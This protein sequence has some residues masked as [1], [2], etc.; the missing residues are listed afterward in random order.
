L[1]AA[2]GGI[3]S[4]D[5]PARHSHRRPL[6]MG[7]VTLGGFLGRRVDLNV[8][9]LLAGFDSPVCLGFEADALGDGWQGDYRRRGA[10]DTDLHKWLEAACCA[11]AGAHGELGTAIDHVAETI[12]AAQ[13][14]AGFIH[15]HRSREA[16]LDPRA[17]NELYV[18]GH[19]FEAAVAHHRATGEDALLDAARRWADYLHEHFA[20]G[21]P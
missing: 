11:L 20:A 16:G 2:P 5:W 18:A 9:S 14:P 17:R 21:H 19:L 15:T 12:L 7:A 4:A 1:S 3:I 10:A 13:A 8:H 6:P